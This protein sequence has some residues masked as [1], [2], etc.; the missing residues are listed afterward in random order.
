MTRTGA[1]PQSQKQEIP[2]EP[3]SPSNPMK[4]NPLAVQPSNPRATAGSRE[5][6]SSRTFLIG[7]YRRSLAAKIL[8]LL[9]VRKEPA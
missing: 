7:V 8:F 4:G 3:N 6:Q 9:P 2:N 5:P 1:A